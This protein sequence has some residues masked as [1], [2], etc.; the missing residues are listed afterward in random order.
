MQRSCPGTFSPPHRRFSSRSCPARLKRAGRPKQC[1]RESCAAMVGSMKCKQCRMRRRSGPRCH[2]AW[3]SL[4]SCRVVWFEGTRQVRKQASVLPASFG[5]TV[6]LEKTGPD[7]GWFCAELLARCVTVGPG[8]A[9]ASAF[10]HDLQLHGDRP[11]WRGSAAANFDGPGPAASGFAKRGFPRGHGLRRRPELVQ[12]TDRQ[13]CA[14]H[15]AKEIQLVGR[16]TA[17]N[18]QVV[19]GSGR[20][21]MVEGGAAR[22]QFATSESTS[23]QCP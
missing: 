6:R 8:S 13:Q 17:R 15:V 12:A 3:L 21:A 14:G 11:Q 18:K 5:F 16:V 20:S 7:S 19:V 4:Q 23:V 22:P 10:G 9:G 1:V 2:C